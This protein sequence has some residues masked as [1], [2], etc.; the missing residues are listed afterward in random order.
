[1][2]FTRRRQYPREGRGHVRPVRENG[3]TQP[4]DIPQIASWV[5]FPVFFIMTYVL[6]GLGI[7]TTLDGEGLNY[8][9]NNITS[10]TA[11]DIAS[12]NKGG[13]E[14]LMVP[15]GAWITLA[16]VHL[17][18]A[19][20]AGI[21]SYITTSIN[22][23]DPG[24]DLSLV[25]LSCEECARDEERFLDEATSVLCRDLWAREA[26]KP[27]NDTDHDDR[28]ERERGEEGLDRE[29]KV[30]GGTNDGVNDR[31]R[32]SG[33]EARRSKEKYKSRLTSCS[34]CLPSSCPPTSSSSSRTYLA[35]TTLTCPKDIVLPCSFLLGPAY[36][37]LRH[38]VTDRHSATRDREEE[39]DEYSDNH[40]YCPYC[41]TKVHMSSRHCRI[42]D[43]CVHNFDHHCKWLNNCIGARNYRYFL[44]TVSSLFTLV[45][46]ELVVAT[47][48]AVAAPI[49]FAGGWNAQRILGI[50]FGTKR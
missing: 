37:G 30:G 32:R 47:L 16:I 5:V 29:E 42:C 45:L 49:R 46:L 31:A 48:A 26:T 35:P 21:T 14:L 43:K 17:L 10:S 34:N 40:Y 20:V 4:F 36:R 44:G 13:G 50:I 39:E 12:S 6:I 11:A 2:V 22:P 7:S 18:L 1:M 27:A 24:L 28:G 9:G 23:M 8:S 3:W 15:L 38:G 41:R 25:R 19:I 33:K